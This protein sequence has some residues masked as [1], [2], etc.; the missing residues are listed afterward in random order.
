MLHDCVNYTLD[1]IIETVS[2]CVYVCV[3]CK[4][5]PHYEGREGINVAVTLCSFFGHPPRPLKIPICLDPS[6]CCM[7]ALT[8]S[9]LSA[10]ILVTW[11]WSSGI[12]TLTTLALKSLWLHSSDH[13]AH[14]ALLPSKP[15]YIPLSSVT[16]DCLWFRQRCSHDGSNH[17]KS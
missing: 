15:S 7:N 8:R 10:E 1:F 9:A 13:N 6:V 2:V 14:N 12:P 5:K 16:Y 11:M 4:D 3:Y 17:N